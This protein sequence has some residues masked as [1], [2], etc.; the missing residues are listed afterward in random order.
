MAG[1]LRQPL[2]RDVELLMRLMRMRADRE[3]D[4]RE[5]LGDG[6]VVGEACDLRR[7]R[8]HPADAGGLGPRDI[9]RKLLGEIRKVQMAMR[10]DQH[11][12]A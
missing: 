7:D 11:H 4:R 3:P 2:G 10:V 9:G 6:G 8:H 5:A 1:Q 12:A